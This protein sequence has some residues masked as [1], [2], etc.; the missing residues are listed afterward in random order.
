M[1]WYLVMHRDNFTVSITEYK[2]HVMS[3]YELSNPNIYACTPFKVNHTTMDFDAF[4]SS[5]DH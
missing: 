3:S 5:S 2:T 4:A 1:A